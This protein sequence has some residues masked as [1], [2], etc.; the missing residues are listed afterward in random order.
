[1]LNFIFHQSWGCNS[2]LFVTRNTE[3]SVS[4]LTCLHFQTSRHADLQLFCSWTWLSRSLVSAHD[5][6]L[7]WCSVYFRGVVMCFPAC[8]AKFCFAYL[9]LVLLSHLD[10]SVLSSRQDSC[11]WTGDLL[12][13]LALC[14]AIFSCSIESLK[15]QLHLKIIIAGLWLHHSKCSRTVAS[16][17]VTPLVTKSV[18][19]FVMAYSYLWLE[20]SS[21]TDGSMHTV[22]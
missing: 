22:M 20:S 19:L 4:G 10:P 14:L 11:W 12:D 2:K 5:L 17:A 21:K 16:Q 6:A 7:V 18:W 9:F 1:M 15:W 13:N 8:S 3:C